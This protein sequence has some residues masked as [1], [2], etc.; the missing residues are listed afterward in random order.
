MSRQEPR[1]IDDE[2]VMDAVA[3]SAST[4]ERRKAHRVRPEEHA[5]VEQVEPLL[6]CHVREGRL[7][8]V[9]TQ[10]CLVADGHRTGHGMSQV[11][12]SEGIAR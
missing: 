10:R 8:I 12:T 1:G 7:E 2:D 6:H 11:T 5:V 3:V 4:E 9:Q